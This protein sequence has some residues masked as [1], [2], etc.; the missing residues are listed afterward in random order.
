MRL[1]NFERA[2]LLVTQKF[3]FKLLYHSDLFTQTFGN[4]NGGGKR[5]AM[6]INLFQR[7]MQRDHFSF[8]QENNDLTF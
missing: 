1:N 4:T 8:L 5:N 2:L 3:A 7:N 6:R